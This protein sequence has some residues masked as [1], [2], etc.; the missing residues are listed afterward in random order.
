MCPLDRLPDSLAAAVRHRR[1]ER[2]APLGAP[3]PVAACPEDILVVVTGGA[4]IKATVC[5]SWNGGTRAV[6][7][8]V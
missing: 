6:F 5:P 7:M 8:P 3:I 4:G 2:L 1:R